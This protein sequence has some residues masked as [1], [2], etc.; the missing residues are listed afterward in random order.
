MTLKQP[1]TKILGRCG[2]CHCLFRA[3]FRDAGRP[4]P[5]CPLCH[6]D[7]TYWSRDGQPLGPALEYSERDRY[8]S[9]PT[10]AKAIAKKPVYHITQMRRRAPNS[11]S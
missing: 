6:G 2:T 11:D 8:F 3:E 5:R 7:G 9:K 1:A 10:V 4:P